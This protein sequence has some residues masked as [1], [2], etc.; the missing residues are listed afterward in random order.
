MKLIKEI[1][2]EYN[3]ENNNLIACLNITVIKG[4]NIK[5]DEIKS[6]RKSELKYK[7][8]NSCKGINITNKNLKWQKHV[9]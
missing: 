7:T 9:I 3:K 6:Q 2:Y 5:N 1:H 8:H 4:N